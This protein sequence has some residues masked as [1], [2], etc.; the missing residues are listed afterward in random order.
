M[1]IN[2]A[3]RRR[4]ALLCCLGAGFGTLF[5]SSVVTYTVPFLSSEL[6]AETNA[7]QWFLAAYSLTFGLGL[8]PGGRLGDVYG[9]RGLLIAG[10]LVFMIAA[11]AAGLAPTIWLVVL[12]RVAQGVGAGLI[13][14]QV[15]AIIQDEFAGTARVKALALYSIAGASAAIVGPLAAG[16]ALTW[17]PVEF[18]WRVVLLLNIPIILATAVLA[19][20]SLD[21]PTA[22]ARTRAHVD[23]PGIVVLAVIVFFVT[24]PVI[25]PGVTE[26]FLWVMVGGVLVLS[27]ALL[28]WERHYVS[29]G[30]IPLF[31]P[32]LMR[33]RGFVG[34]NV[35]ALLWFGAVVSQ[36]TII[37]IFLLRDGQPLL[38]ALLLAPAS[39]GRIVSSSW[40]SRLYSRFGEKIITAGLAAQALS[41]VALIVG[42]QVA[43]ADGLVALIVVLECWVGVTAGFVEPPLR[44]VTLGFAQDGY[45]GVAASFLQLTQRLSATFCVALATGLV[46]G[47]ASGV[48]TADGLRNGLLLCA[49]LLVAAAIISGTVLT[50]AARVGTARV[51]TMPSPTARERDDSSPAAI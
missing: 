30:R 23:V 44:A 5:D 32:A 29:R 39:V 14:A 20:V 6:G 47:A 2:P 27:I 25:D 49:A 24:L 36:I 26:S 9:R 12:A 51:R 13:S 41:S 31:V 34:G 19:L 28:L 18:G 16:A 3:R 15:L 22:S 45:R 4:F 38:I 8:V 40:S 48:A 21:R 50:P 35:V 37:T 7:I 33:S 43:S 10:L 46:I 11:L 1:S 42:T 17:L